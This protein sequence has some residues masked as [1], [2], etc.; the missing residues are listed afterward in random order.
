MKKVTTILTAAL[1]LFSVFA[2][3]SGNDPVNAK[4]RAAFAND[5]SKA[6]DVSWEKSNEFYFATFT[7]NK[8]EINAA[9]SEDGE[10]IG[11]GRVIDFSQ[12]PL[13]VSM[14]LSKKYN[15][16]NFPKKAMELNYDGT[17]RYSL[18]IE[19]EKQILKLK[20]S[21]SGN[22]EVEKKIKKG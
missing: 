8:T 17:T 11:T 22:I 21:V 15:G 2:F 14:A 18:T 5:F 20:C 6:S 9:Y 3:A 13:S 10:L 1:M 19:N 16:Y 7:V 4:V 12:M